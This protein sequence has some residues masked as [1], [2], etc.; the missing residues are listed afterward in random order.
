MTAPTVDA[1]VRIS[2]VDKL[3]GAEGGAVTTALQGINLDIRRGEF[4]SLIGPSG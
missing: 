2:G 3:F 1:V 4:V